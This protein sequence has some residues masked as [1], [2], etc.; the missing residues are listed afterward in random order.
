MFNSGN[1]SQTNLFGA[2]YSLFNN[3]SGFPTNSGGLFGQGSNLMNGT[4]GFSLGKSF[5]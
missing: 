5:K 4:G 2:P 3:N 1:Q